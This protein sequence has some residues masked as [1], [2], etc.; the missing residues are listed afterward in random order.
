MRSNPGASSPWATT[1]TTARLSRSSVAALSHTCASES[2][3]P[4]CRPPSSSVATWCWTVPNRRRHSC[5]C[6]RNGLR[7]GHPRSRHQVA[8][9]LHLP[10]DPPRDV[11]RAHHLPRG[12]IE[13]HALG[14]AHGESGVHLRR[15][16]LDVER[17]DGEHV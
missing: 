1:K 2:T 6:L 15:R 3:R 4:R 14:G 17:V 12:V 7:R 11:V 13:V 10:A 9:V 16:R 5:K 8:K